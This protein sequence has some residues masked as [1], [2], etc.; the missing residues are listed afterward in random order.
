MIVVDTTVWID[1]LRGDDATHVHELVALI[2][3]DAG[4]GI[5]DVILTEVL[6]GVR[7]EAEAKRVERRLRDADFSRLATCSHLR[8]HHPR[9]PGAL[10]S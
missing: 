10:R 5:T 3:E 8:V 2:S 1:F 6:H 7:T 9:A 4:I